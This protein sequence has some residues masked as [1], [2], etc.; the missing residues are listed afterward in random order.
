MIVRNVRAPT[1]S[2]CRPIMAVVLNETPRLRA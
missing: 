2:L 1:K